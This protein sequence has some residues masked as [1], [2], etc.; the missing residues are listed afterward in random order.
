MNDATTL[1]LGIFLSVLFIMALWESL[2]PRRRRVL[3][4][5]QHWSGNLLLIMLDAL[6]VRLLLPAGAV[7]IALWSEAQQ[8]GLLHWLHIAQTPVGIVLAVILLDL[9]IYLQHRI[10]HFSPMLWRLHMVHHADR[11]L[12]VTSG[13]R[14]HPLEI[15]LSM[16][17]KY[18]AIIALGAPAMA[19]IIFEVLLN[20]MAMFNHANIY[21]PPAL[22]RLLR[23]LIVTPDMHRVH[24]SV[25]RQE[26]NSNFGFNLSL[27]DRCF[28][29]YT[30]QPRA[31]HEG[32]RIGLAQYQQAPTHRIGWMLRLPFTG[33]PGQYPGQQSGKGAH[34]ER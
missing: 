31:G 1:R 9:V 3:P 5:A 2:A 22:D 19:V 11:D 21:L 33:N 26:T 20:G 8:A 18:A 32:M 10:F 24:H 27:W 17:I 4:R 34:D 15:I 29:S 28:S 30:A 14:F 12:D 13:L 16:L 6:L 25:M 7:A 23:K